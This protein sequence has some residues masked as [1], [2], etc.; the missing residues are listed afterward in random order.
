MSEQNQEQ[1][2]PA[3][4]GEPTLADAITRHREYYENL[5]GA[6]S[7][8]D[9]AQLRHALKTTPQPPPEAALP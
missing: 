7:P 6:L 3:R 4:H 9:E 5:A 1:R 8:E 2:S